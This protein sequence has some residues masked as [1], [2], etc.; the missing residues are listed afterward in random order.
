VYQQHRECDPVLARRTLQI[1]DGLFGPGYR[2]PSGDKIGA[3]T[4]IVVRS[5]PR[6]LKFSEPL[7]GGLKWR[8]KL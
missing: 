1:T 4:G 5:V 6:F 3:E 2:D 8:R 7:A